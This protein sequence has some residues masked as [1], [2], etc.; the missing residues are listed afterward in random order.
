MLRSPR[1]PW[2]SYWLAFACC[3]TGGASHGLA[4]ATVFIARER[5]GLPISTSDAQ[6]AAICL[7]NDATC[8][9]R[10]TGHFE[11]T[12]VRLMNPWTD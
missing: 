4:Y 7:S 5:A 1:S 12:G 6:I 8:A 10:N 2:P 11:A 3:R 9:T